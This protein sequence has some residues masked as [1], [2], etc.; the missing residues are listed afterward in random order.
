MK[1]SLTKSM[2]GKNTCPVKIYQRIMQPVGSL[3][4]IISFLNQF[5]DETI[6]TSAFNK[7]FFCFHE[8]F[9]YSFFKLISCGFC[10][11]YY[12]Y[13]V[14]SKLTFNYKPDKQPGNCIGLACSGTCLN[15]VC[16]GKWSI[17]YVEFIH[18][19]LKVDIVFFTAH[20][21]RS[22]ESQS[23]Q[24]VSSYF[25]SLRWA[26]RNKP[27]PFGQISLNLIKLDTQTCFFEAALF[28]D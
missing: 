22:L 4:M 16:S 5:I 15:K 3:F 13:L 24:R 7:R 19:N 8:L 11:C 17:Y 21:L 6:N 20:S 25:F 27:K 28:V 12:Q 23:T 2:Y 18:K 9:S 26:K 1:Y 10:K 14:C